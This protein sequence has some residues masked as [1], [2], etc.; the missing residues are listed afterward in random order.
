MRK[1]SWPVPLAMARPST[2]TP[3]SPPR[4][5]SGPGRAL[6]DRIQK[7]YDVSDQAGQEL[8]QQCCEAVNRLEALAAQIRQDGE[9]IPDGK[10]GRR[11][12]PNLRDEI[13]NRS[14]ICK[15]LKNLGVL[16]QPG[17]TS[18]SFG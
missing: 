8:L 15:A 12:H 6:W 1:K 10:G 16:D 13:A 4:E 3:P 18:R 17:R 9:L 7:D 11:S 5:L 2:A 14:F